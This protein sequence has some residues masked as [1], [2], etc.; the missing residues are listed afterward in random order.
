MKIKKRLKKDVKISPHLGSMPQ[1]SL[2]YSAIVLSELNLP[3]L[4]KMSVICISEEV[5]VNFFIVSK[6]LNLAM[7]MMAIFAHFAWSVISLLEILNMSN[8]FYPVFFPGHNFLG[9]CLV[10]V[11]GIDNVLGC[12]ISCAVGQGQEPEEEK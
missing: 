5:L 10:S 6:L 4:R 3:A 11:S 9:A 7:F 12:H 2:A 8:F 1:I